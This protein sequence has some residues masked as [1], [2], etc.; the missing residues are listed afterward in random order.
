MGSIGGGDKGFVECFSVAVSVL[1]VF[2]LFLL[3]W[4]FAPGD[5]EGAGCGGEMLCEEV[6]LCGLA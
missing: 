4:E 5:G 1:V 2:F 3:T 6:R